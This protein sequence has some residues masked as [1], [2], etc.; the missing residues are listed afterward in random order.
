MKRRNADGVPL[1][2]M[3]PGSTVDWSAQ[4]MEEKWRHSISLLVR[5]KNMSERQLRPE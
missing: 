4:A 1:F 3:M 5:R 2:T